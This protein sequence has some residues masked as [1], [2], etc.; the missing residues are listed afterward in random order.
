MFQQITREERILQ[1]RELTRERKVLNRKDKE[2]QRIKHY[3]ANDNSFDKG[4]IELPQNQCNQIAC[5]DSAKPVSYTHLTLPTK[6]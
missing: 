6:A 5:G 3:Y 4:N 2:K 1:N